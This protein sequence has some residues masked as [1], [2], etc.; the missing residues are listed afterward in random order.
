ML[1]IVILYNSKIPVLLY[2]SLASLDSG[3]VHKMVLVG[4]MFDTLLSVSNCANNKAAFQTNFTFLKPT[5]GC[6]IRLISPTKHTIPS[7]VVEFSIVNSSN[8]VV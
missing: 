7:E 8:N 6:G 1:I 2:T 5:N 3:A 4:S